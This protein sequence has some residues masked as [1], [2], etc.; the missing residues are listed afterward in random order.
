MHGSSCCALHAS[1]QQPAFAPPFSARCRA[2]RFDMR[3]VDHLRIVRSPV[4]SQFAEQV[5]PNATPC[6]A[7]KAVIDC[8]RGPVSFRT[9][10][11]AAATL[12]N[13]NDTADHPTV[14]G[15]FNPTNIGRQM[16]LNAC[17]LLIAQPEQISAHLSSPNTNQYRIVSAERLMSFDPRRRWYR[18]DVYSY[19]QPYPGWRYEAGFGMRYCDR[20]S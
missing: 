4:A 1:G 11:P 6:P 12:E 15:S 3:R 16:G 20:I 19:L 14:V 5:F 9:I 13:V 10:A 2:V 17:P 8:G 18:S 7:H